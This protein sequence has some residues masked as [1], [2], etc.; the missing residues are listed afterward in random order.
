[1]DPLHSQKWHVLVDYFPPLDFFVLT[2]VL[3]SSGPQLLRTVVKTKKS[4]RKVVN[5]HMP[6][7]RMERIRRA[8][9]ADST[10]KHTAVLHISLVVVEYLQVDSIMRV[11]ESPREIAPSN[12]ISTNT[13]AR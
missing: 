5:E 9:I 2:M 3:S 13:C 12:Q 11:V 8:P 7:L 10:K 6:L 1:M 4:W